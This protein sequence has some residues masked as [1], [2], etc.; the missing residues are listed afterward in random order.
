MY[1]GHAII[2]KSID[3]GG[4]A[5]KVPMKVDY[6]VRALVE[7][8]NHYGGEAVRAVD[9]AKRQNIPEAYLGQLLPILHKLGLIYSR[10]GP[11][12]GHT[13]AMSPREIDL[14]MVTEGIEGAHSPLDCID[15][16]E[17]C[18]LSGICAQRGVWATVEEAIQQV[19]KSTT[20]GDLLDRQKQLYEVNAEY[21]KK[22]EV[23]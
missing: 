22:I 8:A 15:V 6:G 3:S 16:P 11:Q 2:R 23:N 21:K 14:R 10:R 1:R 20:I 12:G 4:I 18:S 7:L 19:L 9:I 17:C 5:V 13:L